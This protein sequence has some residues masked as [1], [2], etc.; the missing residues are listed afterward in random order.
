MKQPKALPSPKYYSKVFQEVSH[1]KK[2]VKLTQSYPLVQQRKLK[3]QNHFS[4][5]QDLGESSKAINLQK[6]L[7]RERDP[8]KTTPKPKRKAHM[9]PSDKE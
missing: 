8:S 1:K 6:Y 7:A 5:L 9:E 3:N 2:N 4:V